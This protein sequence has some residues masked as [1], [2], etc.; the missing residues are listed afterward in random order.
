MGTVW[1]SVPARLF[2]RDKAL[3]SSAAPPFANIL[4]IAEHRGRAQDCLAGLWLGLQM[5][6]VRCLLGANKVRV[7]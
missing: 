4:R 6:A 1:G 5:G 3:T 2:D 7:W